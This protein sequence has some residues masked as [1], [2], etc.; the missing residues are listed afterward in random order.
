[1]K[2]ENVADIY[3]L[4][5]V[6]LGLLFHTLDNSQ[7]GVYVN[8]YTCQLQGDLNIRLFQQAWKE[9]LDRYSVL[10]TAFVW[11]GL[12]E[13][14]QVVRQQVE[15]PWFEKDWREL[16]ASKQTN[17]LS[18]FLRSDRKQGF[19]LEQAPLL[20]LT[21]ISLGEKTVQ[22][23]WSSHHLLFDG[24]SLPIIWQ[25]LL[26]YYNGLLQGEI[27][28][29]SAVRPFKDYI[30]WRQTQD[31]TLAKTL[32]RSQLQGFSAPTPLPAA[33]TGFRE[34]DQPYLQQIHCLNP[35]L[36][37]ALKT[38]AKQHQLTLNTLIQGAWALLL[39]HYGGGEQVTYG[40]VMSGRP[41]ELRGIETMV[42]L[43][44]NTLP[45]HVSLKPE[46]PLIPWLH[47]LQQK[48]LDLRPYE[49]TPLTD[50]QRWSD[51][52]A[53][54][55][56]FESIVV[57]ENYPAV[58]TPNLD[59]EICNIQYFEQSNYPLALLIIPGISLDLRLLF[60]L[61]R[62]EDA[63]ISRLLD[64]LELLLT[65]FVENPKII[66]ADLP[67]L[68]AL[69]Q[70]NL[71][72]WQPFE[73]PCNRCIH[74]LIE[75]QAE[76]TPN[77]PAVVYESQTL[78][79]AALNQ[80]A[81]QLAHELRSQGVVPG[82]RVA[83]CLNRSLEMVIGIFGV[84]K[85][86]A[87]Y[88]PLDPTYPESRLDY[89]LK[90]TDPQILLTQRSVHLPE[91]SIPSLY[92]DDYFSEQP[93]ASTHNLPNL[94][95]PEDLAYIIYTSGSTGDPKG[96]MVSHRNLVYSTTAR[97]QVYPETVDRFLLLSS[98]AFDSSVAGVFW[99]LYQ[100]GTLV[101]SPHR[102]EQDLA[103]LTALIEQHK[104]T[105]TLCIPTLYQLLLGDTQPQKLTT[106]KTVIVAGEACPRMLAQ[107]HYAKLPNAT[108]Y[109]EYGPTEATVWST[110]YPVPVVLEPG[111][112]PI[113]IPIPNTHI[114]LLDKTLKPVPTGAIGE[115]YIG[116]EGV[117]Q[118][119]LNQPEHS[120]TAFSNSEFRISNS[121]LP[122]QLYYRTGDLA[123]Y[124]ADGCL[125]WLGRCDRQ[126]KIRGY[127][128]ELSE[129]EEALL[130]CKAVKAVAVVPQPS[131]PKSLESLVSDL[132]TLAPVEAEALL[133]A[134]EQE[135]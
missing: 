117:T 111:P 63:A 101:I 118:G 131:S 49:A 24:W 37:T 133:I 75:A 84:L 88:I 102:I 61:R 81:N 14:L 34:S 76:A 96:V 25:D 54:T 98:I 73:Y 10:R 121:E 91:R 55:P 126:V 127:R 114:Q 103:Q 45:V 47:R 109:N 70:Q 22:L 58:K 28:Q 62:F 12:D 26:T 35:S 134:V 94:A 42:G 65:A 20:R 67:R 132:M 7:Q 40:S 89:C 36:T 120:E 39:S 57:F 30:A 122:H 135:N 18:E 5:P 92:L 90:D 29:L 3:P 16:S 99:T 78:S 50:I 68:T 51:L 31:F 71:T 23:V 123:R 86:G 9:I 15:L 33:R 21:L 43:F 115:I 8:Q 66:L 87:T 128:I 112:I 72:D 85:A 104:I 95:K 107:Q 32:W 60:D 6:Q 17:L 19:N 2:L 48:L 59:F 56:L 108:L 4:S 105:H 130:E 1:M 64:H 82:G 53:A 124:R 77:A 119:Y 80:R 110:V 13:P 97:S 129:I 11:E 125:E 52:P 46:Q 41:A 27:P 44:I 83:L 100:G 116:G 69:E 106:L 74:Q 93:I 113:G 79:Y 38:I